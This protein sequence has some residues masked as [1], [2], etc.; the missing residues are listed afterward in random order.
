MRSRSRLS[1]S[2]SWLSI[3]RAPTI[4]V[5]GRNVSGR[6]CGFTSGFFSEEPKR[7]NRQSDSDNERRFSFDAGSG[8]MDV[9]A[10]VLVACSADCGS[11][12]I[13]LEKMELCGL[14]FFCGE[15]P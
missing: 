11:A 10:M 2:S 8:V 9:E 5:P 4:D 15:A 6:K 13:F 1:S 7:L 12:V 14:G 3:F